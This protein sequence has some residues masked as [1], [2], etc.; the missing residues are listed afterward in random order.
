[1]WCIWSN[2]KNRGL[3]RTRKTGPKKV[4]AQLQHWKRRNQKISVRGL[5]RARKTGMIQMLYF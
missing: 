5:S 3:L 2:R 4:M 1:M